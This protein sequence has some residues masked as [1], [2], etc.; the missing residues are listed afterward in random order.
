MYSRIYNKEKIKETDI[1]QKIL[2]IRMIQ[3]V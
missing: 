2:I 3:K 1:V